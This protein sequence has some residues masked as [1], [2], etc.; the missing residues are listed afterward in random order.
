MATPYEHEPT[1]HDLDNIK[2][3]LVSA[4]VLKAASLSKEEEA[5][6]HAE[7]ARHGVDTTALRPHLWCNPNY[8]IIVRGVTAAK[9]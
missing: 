4:N 1:S 5:K 6:V 3:A 2:K 8:C 9:Q 7:L